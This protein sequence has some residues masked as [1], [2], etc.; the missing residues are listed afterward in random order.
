MTGIARRTDVGAVGLR[1][2]VPADF[3]DYRRA[4]RPPSADVDAHQQ[5]LARPG[6]GDV[7]SSADAPTSRIQLEVA[8]CRLQ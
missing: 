5:S 7:L 4:V 8:G 3:F 6:I 2:N 1:C